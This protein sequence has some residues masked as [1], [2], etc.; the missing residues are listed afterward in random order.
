MKLSTGFSVLFLA[1]NLK[2]KMKPYIECQ[3][4]EQN[5]LVSIMY[6]SSIIM[7]MKVIIA[8]ANPC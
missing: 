4:I 5:Q 6:C 1:E 3:H 2:K 7:M 8:A